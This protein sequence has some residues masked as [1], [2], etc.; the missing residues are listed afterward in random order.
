[1]A[2]REIVVQV[3][4][5]CHKDQNQVDGIQTHTIKVDGKEVEAEACTSCWWKA[6]KGIEPFSKVGRKP[7]KAALRQKKAVVVPW[8]G[9]AWEFSSH[10]LVAMGKRNLNPVDVLWV[11]ENPE[12]AYPGDSEDTEVRMGKGL[13]V[14]VSPTRLRIVT[15]SDRSNEQRA[16]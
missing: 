16:S 5:L 14:V 10:A 1:M 2:R 4:D 6:I 8:P 9:S 12:T 11:A 15:A 3:C 13:K 7:K